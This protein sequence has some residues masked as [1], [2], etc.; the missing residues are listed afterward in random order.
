MLG[1]EVILSDGEVVQLGGAAYDPPG[2]DLRALI[3]GS[4]GTL[5]VVTEITVRIMP[6]PEKLNAKDPTKNAARTERHT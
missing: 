1:L 5:A 3:I 2:Y 6:T 4:E